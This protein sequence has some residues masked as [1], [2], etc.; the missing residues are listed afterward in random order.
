MSHFVFRLVYENDENRLDT[1]LPNF[2]CCRNLI[3]LEH[4]SQNFNTADLTRKG[5]FPLIN[6][7][8][9][10]GSSLF[11]TRYLPDIVKLQ[12]RLGNRFG[13][14]LDR[15]KITNMRIEE[16][17]QQIN[18]GSKHSYF[19][20]LIHIILVQFLKNAPLPSM[21]Y[22]RPYVCICMYGALLRYLTVRS[23]LLNFAYRIS[24]WYSVHCQ[25]FS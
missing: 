14:C 4:F 19:N 8:L 6:K 13:Q 22:A 12:L 23:L 16:F 1:K 11:A 5:G 17:E 3:S 24:L 25:Y 18:G 9:R 15:S 2:W 21:R 10:E 20:E 7:L